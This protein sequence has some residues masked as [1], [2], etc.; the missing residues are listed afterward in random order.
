MHTRITLDPEHVMPLSHTTTLVKRPASLIALR[1]AEADLILIELARRDLELSALERWYDPDQPRVPAG[2]T[3]GGQWAGGNG[4]GGGSGTR[5][6]ALRNP[7]QEAAK[8]AIEAALAIYAG[9]TGANRSGQQAVASFN[10]A[11]YVPGDPAT[12]T[13]ERV[14][15][16]ERDDVNAACPRFGEVQSYA[17]EATKRADADGPWF[18]TQNRGTAIHKDIQN[19]IRALRD[20]DFRAEVSALKSG[21]S[22]YG[23]PGTVRV[24][25]FEHV[26]NGTTCIYDIKTGDKGLSA[27][28][29]VELASTA[30][31][32]YPDTRRIVV[33]EVRTER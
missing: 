26:G 23:L 20:P 15:A 13:A 1:R 29:M 14:R 5:P 10:A 25:V 30:T 33:T 17:K 11:E 31:L 4:S 18:S 7:R 22:R 16:L 19:Q 2:Q 6:T 28:R 24:D 9:L 3:G 8:R 27:A 12:L 32:I 21:D